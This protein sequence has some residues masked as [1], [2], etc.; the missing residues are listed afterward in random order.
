MLKYFHRLQ[1]IKSG[2]LYDAYICNQNLH[3]CNIQT[4]YSS[5][6]FKHGIQVLHSN[7]VFKYNVYFR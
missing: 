7:M 1:N 2:S 6:T 4:W 3:A 5:I